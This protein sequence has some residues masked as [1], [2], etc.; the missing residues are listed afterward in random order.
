MTAKAAQ[1]RN[2]TG[3]FL[4]LTFL[5]LLS[6]GLNGYQWYN[7]QLDETRHQN[8]ILSLNGE[9][10]RLR[11][12][13]AELR[14]TI[15]QIGVVTNKAA[16]VSYNDSDFDTYTIN[17]SQSNLKLYWTDESGLPF[18]NLGKLKDWLEERGK[19]MV[20][21][22]NAG[23]Y[24]TDNSPQGLFIDD[25]I[26]RRPID[27]GDSE[28]FENFYLKP[29][30]VFYLDD[31]GANIMESESFASEKPSAHLATQSGPMLLI[32]GKIHPKFREGSSNLN[33]RNGVG[34]INNETVVFIISRQAVNFYDFAM[35]FK[36]KFSCKNALYLDGAIS[37]MYLP[38]LDRKDL[39]GNLGPLLVE[40][41]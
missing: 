16:R 36:E 1:Q 23:M 11:E 22:I 17:L 32:N 30:G 33:I 38:E 18:R 27:L 6:L 21:G 13:Q 19:R 20:F 34:I 7:Y 25:S 5:I 39:S 8:D 24:L 12:E 37:K 10:K 4:F 15:A 40:W 31:S 14:T 29:N 3:R 9:V 2:F 41:E 26:E 35:V 28:G